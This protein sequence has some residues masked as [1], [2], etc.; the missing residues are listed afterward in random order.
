MGLAI[1]KPNI[2]TALIAFALLG[3]AAPASAAENDT[4]TVVR[5]ARQ[6][7]LDAITRDI[8]ITQD[9]QAELQHEIDE[10]D[11]DRATLNESLIDAG[12][13]VQKLEGELDRTEQRLSVLM[14]DED[15]LRQSL[16]DRRA[17]LA[18]VLAALQRMGHRPPPAILVRPEDALAAIRSAILLG[19]VVPDLRSV[20]NKLAEDLRQLVALRT[21]QEAERDRLRADATALIEGRTRITLLLA[22]KQRQRSASMDELASEQRR[23]AAL[24]S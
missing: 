7:E 15:K 17:V 8:Q 4:V 20:A 11:K 22:E 19:A 12:K 23:A 16:A 9:R 3:A 10:L 5:N 1:V 21:E 2:P 14:A 24:A 6:A 18:Q 13:Q